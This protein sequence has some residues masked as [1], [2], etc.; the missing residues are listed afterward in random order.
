MS[1]ID[2]QEIVRYLEGLISYIKDE[3][4]EILRETADIENDIVEL[5]GDRSG[6]RVAALSGIRTYTLTLMAKNKK[7]STIEKE[8]KNV[9]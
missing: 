5:G 7:H 4:T 1:I 6:F 2:K 9:I 8:I 3:D